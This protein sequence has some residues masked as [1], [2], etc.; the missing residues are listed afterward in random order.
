MLPRL[1]QQQQKKLVNV[2]LFIYI[3]EETK[4]TYYI[5]SKSKN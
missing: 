5:F 1:T 4:I 2:I 3:N